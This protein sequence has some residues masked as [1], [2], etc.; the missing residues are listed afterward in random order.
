MRAL[1]VGNHITAI[2]VHWSES[3]CRTVPCPGAELCDLC[4]TA[5]P[6]RW[7]AFAPALLPGKCRAVVQLTYE[8][9]RSLYDGMDT[10]N[11]FRGV[12][13][14]LKRITPQRTARVVGSFVGRSVLPE[15]YPSWD[16]LE[17]LTHLFG[18]IRAY[19][20]LLPGDL[21]NVFYLPPAP[22][23]QN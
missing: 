6:A 17:S 1:L 15:D 2:H 5:R 13:A 19:T 3:S 11:T 16:P 9:T 18:P 14:H 20:R 4:R 7:V 8:A 12:Q 21:P 23:I 10:L 22:T